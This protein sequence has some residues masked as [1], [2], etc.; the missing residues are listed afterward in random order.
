MRLRGAPTAARTASS[1]CRTAPR[2]NSKIDTFPHPIA[3]SSGKPRPLPFVGSRYAVRQMEI[4]Y[5]YFE[6]R[7]ALPAG[8]FEAVSQE[9]ADGCLVLRLRR[10]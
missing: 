7:I 3:S 4:P 6:R 9:L 2:A 8:V 10:I 1:C 5:G